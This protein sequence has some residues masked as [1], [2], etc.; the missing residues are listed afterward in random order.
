MNVLL[1]FS[2]TFKH[3]L[4]NCTTRVK[5]KMFYF[6]FILKDLDIRKIPLPVLARKSNT[7]MFSCF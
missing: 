5:E 6:R 1:S 7:V 3:D 2:I 4:C